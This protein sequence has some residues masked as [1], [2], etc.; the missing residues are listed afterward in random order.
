MAF[1]NKPKTGVGATRAQVQRKLVRV[2]AKPPKIKTVKA[3]QAAAAAQTLAT[4]KKRLPVLQPKRNDSPGF[5]RKAKSRV[6]GGIFGTK[7]A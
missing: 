3:A 7:H 4:N 6:T 5:L 2:G 1:K